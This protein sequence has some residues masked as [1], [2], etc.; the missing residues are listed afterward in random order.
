MP[1][2]EYEF[3]TLPIYGP[4]YYPVVEE[5]KEIRSNSAKRAS[6][7]KNHPVVHQ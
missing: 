5:K 7:V 1:D 2:F 3:H 4:I 6:P